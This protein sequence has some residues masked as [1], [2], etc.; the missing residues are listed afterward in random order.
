MLTLGSFPPSQL[1]NSTGA[2]FWQKASAAWIFSS[3]ALAN[4]HQATA[5]SM[6]SWWG[7]EGSHGGDRNGGNLGTF[8]ED[9]CVE[10]VEWDTSGIFQMIFHEFSEVQAFYFP[11]KQDDEEDWK[12]NMVWY[13][14]VNKIQQ[15]FWGYRANKSPKKVV[16]KSNLCFLFG[17]T[18]PVPAFSSYQYVRP[19]SLWL[20]ISKSQADEICDSVPLLAIGTS[21]EG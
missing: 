14:Q 5:F 7:Q 2:C 21:V 20:I 11:L 18:P 10:S 9:P 17:T 19:S 4:L 3:R 8:L 6:G 13:S 12:T 16:F 1:E 15:H